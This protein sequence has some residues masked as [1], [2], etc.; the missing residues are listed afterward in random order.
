MRKRL[1]HAPRLLPGVDGGGHGTGP[2]GWQESDPGGERG[3]GGSSMMIDAA[4]AQCPAS[5]SSCRAD[6]DG[7]VCAQS[8]AHPGLKRSCP[9]CA[10]PPREEVTR[11][12]GHGQGVLEEAEPPWCR[13]SP[14]RG[15]HALVICW[16]RS[17]WQPLMLLLMEMQEGDPMSIPCAP[18]GNKPHLDICR[19]AH[20]TKAEGTYLKTSPGMRYEAH[21]H[22][23][24]RS[25]PESTHCWWRVMKAVRR[26]AP[27]VVRKHQWHSLNRWDSVMP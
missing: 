8:M 23:S 22:K 25:R 4:A 24:Q 19:R 20:C 18:T 5:S 16:H 27:H 7:D 14:H 17:I 21:G 6:E 15:A 11:V 2:A 3:R 1:L 13:W 12:K 9:S 10:L 26:A